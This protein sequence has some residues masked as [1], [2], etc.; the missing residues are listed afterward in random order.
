MAGILTKGIKL[1]YATGTS[2]AESYTDLTNLQEIPDMGGSTDSVEVTTLTD[3]AHM[4]IAG[5]KD[6]GD[7]IDFTFLYEPTQF[8]TLNTLSGDNSW[9]L[10]LPDGI[11]GAID[12]TCTFTRECSVR[13]LGKTYNDAMQYT[14]SIKPTSEMVW[15]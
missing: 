11:G 9:K 6:Y 10:S 13:L 14:L 2:S 4:Y 15:G 8:A 3:A 7:S 1:S 5:L 12:T